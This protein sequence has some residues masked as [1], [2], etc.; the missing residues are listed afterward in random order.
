[1]SASTQAIKLQFRRNE[2]VIRTAYNLQTRI[3]FKK[4]TLDQV[5]KITDQ[6]D[7][8]KSIPNASFNLILTHEI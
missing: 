5:D 3:L 4:K 8:S 7:L 6:L 2:L 1:M